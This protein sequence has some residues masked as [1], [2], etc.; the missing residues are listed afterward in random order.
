MQLSINLSANFD[1]FKLYLQH[2]FNVQGIV[3][4]FGHSGSGKS[5]LLRAIAGLNEQLS[6]K[7]YCNNQCLFDSKQAIFVK[8]ELRRIG[9]IF[10]D[11]RLFPHL[12][13]QQNLI[14]ARKRSQSQQVNFEEIIELTALTKLLTKKPAQ[15][16][17]GEKQRV[18][19]ARAILAEPKLLLLDEPLSALDHANKIKLLIVLAKVQKHLKIP[20]LYVSHSLAELQQVAD[21]LLV[22]SHGKIIDHGNIHHVIHRLNQQQPTTIH[23]QTSLTLTVTK[24]DKD[25]GLS[26][27]KLTDN[28]TLYLP[29]LAESKHP[30]NSTL[31]CFI[32][33]DDI[34]ISTQRPH[35]SSIVNHLQGKI[36][37]ANI[38]NEHSMLLTVHCN[39]Q[40]FFSQISVWSYKKLQ[41]SLQKDIF[42]QFKASAIRTFTENNHYLIEE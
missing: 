26:E 36:I 27:L 17:G 28:N 19:L 15:L 7:I 13:V 16:S 31:R 32:F 25:H 5:T 12:N 9:L 40:D 1:H 23:Q 10:Q 39:H 8:P 18:A 6:G 30:I 29:L 42:I 2:E 14:F 20:M 11:S 21:N 33:A 4:I 35:H 24:H 34:S 41:L 22:L 3:G 38:L 37:N